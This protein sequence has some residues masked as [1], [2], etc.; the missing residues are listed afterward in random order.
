MFVEKM[1]VM[2]ITNGR[3]YEKSGY[4]IMGKQYFAIVFI[5]I[6]PI[7]LFIVFVIIIVFILGKKRNTIE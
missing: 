7:K 4:Y 6:V 2:L 5:I 1:P 3:W